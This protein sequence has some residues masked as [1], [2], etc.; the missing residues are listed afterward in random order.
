MGHNG[1]ARNET[2]SHLSEQELWSK[3]LP[4][5]KAGIRDCEME[6]LA[7]GA[8]ETAGTAAR[9][10]RSLNGTPSVAEGF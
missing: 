4:L 3:S 6:G 8:A 5:L 1:R 9:S 10:G 7:N 2:V